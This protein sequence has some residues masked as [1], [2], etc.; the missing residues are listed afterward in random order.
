MK[1]K[2]MLKEEEKKN[3]EKQEKREENMRSL[4]MV[5]KERRE[6]NTKKPKDLQAKIKSPNTGKKRQGKRRKF[7]GEDMDEEH[8]DEWIEE[9]KDN[10]F[11]Q[12][13]EAIGE[14]FVHNKILFKV[15]I[16]N[17]ESENG[18]KDNNAEAGKLESVQTR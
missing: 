18:R 3:K 16:K 7:V 2:L 6:K 4:D 8:L 12:I 9:E 11:G 1:R 14:N 17:K 15:N 10:L 5:I 13:E